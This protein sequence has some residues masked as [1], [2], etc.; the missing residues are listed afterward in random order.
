MRIYQSD[1]TI[2]PAMFV[3]SGGAKNM[4][5]KYKSVDKLQQNFIRAKSVVGKSQKKKKT[6]RQKKQISKK[7]IEFL[8]GIGLKV[9]QK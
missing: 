4:K 6:K 3:V 5:K 9:K 2:A 8:E 7:N 1:N